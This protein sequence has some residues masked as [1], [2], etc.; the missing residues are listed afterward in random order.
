MLV[1][2]NISYPLFL[3]GYKCMSLFKYCSLDSLW[4]RLLFTL[5]SIFIFPPIQLCH[6]KQFIAL[7]V[8]DYKWDV[9]SDLVL[10][11]LVDQSCWNC[12]LNCELN[13]PLRRGFLFPQEYTYQSNRKKNKENGN[14]FRMDITHMLSTSTYIEHMHTQSQ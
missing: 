4:L 8:P 7:S 6:M 9:T 11:S 10:Q 3:T 13:H 2:K 14:I 1:L 12:T 5:T